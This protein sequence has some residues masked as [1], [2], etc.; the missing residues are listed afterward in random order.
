MLYY[1]TCIFTSSATF[2][3]LQV[4]IFLFQLQSV[5]ADVTLKDRRDYTL[6]MCMNES[7]SFGLGGLNHTLGLKNEDSKGERGAGK[8]TENKR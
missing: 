5:I 1:S 3:L 2:K 4:S 7:Q 8:R 6:T